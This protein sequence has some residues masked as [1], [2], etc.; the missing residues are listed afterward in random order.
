[1][2]VNSRYQL[3]LEVDHRPDDDHVIVVVFHPWRKTA[4]FF[5]FH[6]IHEER[7][8]HIVC[9]VP[10][11]DLP[12][13]LLLQHIR[14]CAAL[15]TR[16][17]IADALGR[18]RLSQGE[19]AFHICNIEFLAQR[20]KHGGIILIGPD[21]QGTKVEPQMRVCAQIPQD[22]QKRDAVLA[23]GK[24]HTY[25]LPVSDK[26]VGGYGTQHVGNKPLAI[27]LVVSFFNI[28]LHNCLG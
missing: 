23:P 6:D 3:L 25:P 21:V 7:F 5:V 18:G 16:A 15:E 24:S 27:A 17:H 28:H 8:S 22:V 1:M 20:F 12:D 19:T 11:G 2:P 14:N 10:V 9:M 13:T 4:E 26:I